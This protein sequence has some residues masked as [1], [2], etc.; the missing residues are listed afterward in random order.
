MKQRFEYTLGHVPTSF[1]QNNQ[2]YYILTDQIGSPKLI[3][4]EN[5]NT[6]KQLD[7]DSFGNLITDSNPDFAIPFGFAG[8]LLDNDTGLIRF[9][10]RDYDPETGRWTA[11]DPIGFAGGD[12]NLYVYSD[13]INGIDPEGL[14][15]IAHGARTGAQIGAVVG[16]PVGAVVGGV[17]GAVVG[18]IIGN[19]LS[20]AASGSSEDG[21]SCD[22]SGGGGGWTPD[23]DDIPELDWNDPSTPPVDSDGNEWPW[24][25]PDEQ[26]GDRGGY[27]DPKNKDVSVHPDLNHAPPIG[28]HWDYTNRKKGGA[29]IHPNGNVTP[30]K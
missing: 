6:V 11:R 30:K 12:T 10:Y 17:A 26:G 1:T 21:G 5:G 14:S 18:A 3:A 9:G 28:P 4:D 27:V 15:T 2:R 23:A 20:E 7:Y 22:A 25:G 16:G 8:G 29:R 13:P 19:A 24:R